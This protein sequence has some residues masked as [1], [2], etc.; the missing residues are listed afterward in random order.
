MT[1]PQISIKVTSRTKE[2]NESLKR[3]Q[4]AVLMVGIAQGSKGDARDDGG[5]PNSLLG[6]VHERGSPS[7]GI[8]ARLFL[9][10]G[11]EDAKDDI[12][13]GLK[14]AMQAALKDDADGMNAELEKTGIRAVSAVKTKMRE[15]PF[16][17]LKPSTVK[18]RNRSRQTQGKR[19]NEVK[20]ENIKPLINTG[21]L[22]DAIDFYVE[23]G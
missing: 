13:D 12:K 7:A 5:P 19:E 3:L 21:A 2:L 17:P 11:I 4:K 9:R 1:K 16:A 8:P 6:W 20:G 23:G 18:G 10:P 15:G 14:A 22:R